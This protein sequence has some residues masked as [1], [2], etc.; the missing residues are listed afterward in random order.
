[1]R[2]SYIL[3][4][5]WNTDK[6]LDELSEYL[7]SIAAHVDL[8]I[9]DGSSMEAFN[10]HK[11]LWAN[12]GR[13]LAPDS[14]YDFINGK[15]NGVLTGLQL[16]QYQQVVIA[17]DDVRYELDQLQHMESLLETAHLVVPQNYFTATLW[18]AQWDTSRTLLNRLFYHDYPGTLAVQR[19]FINQ[20]GGYD[21]DVMFENLELIRTVQAAGG[22]IM[23]CDAFFVKR[24]PPAAQHFWSQRVRQAF[25]DNAQPFRLAFFFMLLPV[26]FAST[27]IAWFMPFCLLMM[28]V[29]FAEI[30]RR[31]RNGQQVFAL[32]CSFYAPLWILERGICTWLAL[33]QRLLHGG[34][35]Y[36]GRIIRVAA[37]PIWKLKSKLNAR[38]LSAMVAV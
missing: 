4:I 27:F 16:A 36:N 30:G 3:P 11:F 18:H 23:Y 33:Y 28:A 17:D 2:I 19:D 7:C 6:G 22:T 5:K 13:H 9:V 31:K 20:L 35:S 32:A 29:V 1:M 34:I 8:I 26:L 12:Y 24:L 38:I 25:D 37:N 21:G 10:K 14:A 15:V